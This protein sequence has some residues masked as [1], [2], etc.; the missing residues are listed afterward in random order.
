MIAVVSPRSCRSCSLYSCPYSRSV[1]LKG[2]AER[3]LANLNP[4]TCGWSCD[5]MLLCVA[6]TFL[7]VL[8]GVFLKVLSLLLKLSMSL[9]S[10]FASSWYSISKL[11]A[12]LLL[13]FL[14]LF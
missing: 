7:G 8:I 1:L 13:I 5:L 6:S 9:F 14:Y 3:L 12:Y 2:I 10:S 11:G 4:D